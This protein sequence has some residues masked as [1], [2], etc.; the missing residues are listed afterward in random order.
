M[1]SM[2]GFGEGVAKEV[3]IECRVQVKS[4]NHRYLETRIR[5]N[6]ED[7][8]LNQFIKTYLGKK[9]NRGFI[10]LSLRLE[11][12]D[13]SPEIKFNETLF[14]D[15]KGVY[16]RG[17]ELIN[18]EMTPNLNWIL[19]QPNV[20]SYEDEDVEEDVLYRVAQEALDES[21]EHLLKMRAAEGANLFEDLAGRLSRLES[22][23]LEIQ[24]ES[25]VAEEFR[26][27]RYYAAI[28]DLMGKYTLDENRMAN[29]IAI[30]VEK[31]TIEEEITRL[32]SHIHHFSDIMKGNHSIGKKLDFLLQE[33]NREMNTIGSKSQDVGILH[34]V[35]ECK[36]MIED[37]REQVQNV[38]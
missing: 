15:L 23:V 19:S 17:S 4:V 22:S 31:W 14:K 20:I 3:G 16:E 9:L 37:L 8:K 25:K 28:E 21:I 1:Y 36:S 27:E 29:E 33:M 12:D 24:A 13:K 34:K 10:E 5:Q 2:T 32:L 7:N 30:L 35:V 18:S 6:I 38:E 26:R 11:F